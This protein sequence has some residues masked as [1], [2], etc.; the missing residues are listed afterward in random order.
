[1]AL[2]YFLDK[3]KA[4]IGTL[5]ISSP[6]PNQVPQSQTQSLPLPPI[7][8]TSALPNP[9]SMALTATYSH[10]LNSAHN[11]HLSALSSAFGL[12]PAQDTSV[13]MTSRDSS[14]MLSHPYNALQQTAAMMQSF[15]NN[16]S[17]PHSNMTSHDVTAQ[18]ANG[19]TA[20]P[21]NVMIPTAAAAASYHGVLK[22]EQQSPSRDRTPTL[23]GNH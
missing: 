6:N 13:T 18:A 9:A 16:L 15:Y 8:P 14:A 11:P 22:Q 3:S 4:A 1:M 17:Q 2:A 5:A 7:E 21:H 20:S 10:M 19:S 12:A 23:N